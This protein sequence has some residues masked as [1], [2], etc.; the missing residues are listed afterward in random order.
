MPY[1]NPVPMGLGSRVG[2]TAAQAIGERGTQLAMKRFHDTSSGGI[3]GR[4]EPAKKKKAMEKTPIE[5]LKCLL[6]NGRDDKGGKYESFQ[7]D[8]RLDR[9][10]LLVELVLTDPTKEKKGAAFKELPQQLIHF[11]LALKAP[12]G[13]HEWSGEPVGRWLS[14]LAYRGAKFLEDEEPKTQEE[15]WGLKSRL[16]WD[17]DMSLENKC[18]GSE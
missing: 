11:E 2:L 16:I 17:M 14:A 5:L 8:A 13:L 10:R 9:F 18:K 15:K 3:G 6:V 12:T 4:E 7:G 1:D